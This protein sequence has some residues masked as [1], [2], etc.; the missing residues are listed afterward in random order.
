MP[1]LD[2]LAAVDHARP[3]GRRGVIG[4]LPDGPPRHFCRP[5]VTTSRPQ[6]SVSNVV[7]A[8]RR[9]GVAVEQHVVAPADLAEVVQRLAHRGRRVALHDREQLR[10]HPS[11]GVLDL[12]GREHLAPRHLDGVHL[13]A[14][15]LG[16]LGEQV[17]EPAED[18][19][20]HPVAG[21]EQR[22]QRRLDAGARGAVDEQRLLV[23]RCGRPRGRAPS[24]RSWSPVIHGSYWPTSCADIARSTR[25]SAL[26][27]PG[28]ISSRG[29][30]V[31]RTVHEPG[32]L[33]CRPHRW[34]GWSTST[35]LPRTT[36]RVTRPP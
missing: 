19:H 10:P 20:Q 28:P 31:D 13:G 5:A 7:A 32:L 30:R 1:G 21:L 26:I 23:G 27:G 9:R 24:S 15:A 25:G 8:E 35:A 11:Y 4:A 17:P 29:G 16:D 36:V 3:P 33:S 2:V 34:S 12:L 6:A 18:R 14:A 22:H